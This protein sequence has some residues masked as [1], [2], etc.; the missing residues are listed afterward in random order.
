MNRRRFVADLAKGSALA[1]LFTRSGGLRAAEPAPRS[2]GPTGGSPLKSKRLGVPLYQLL[3]GK[4][5][6]GVPVYQHA[7]GPTLEA[8]ADQARALMSAGV[9]YVRAQVGTAGNATYGAPAAPGSTNAP[10]DR[11]HFSGD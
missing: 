7:S 6:T 2:S 9:R 8:V 5:R 1:A 10:P 3:G 4:C 11:G